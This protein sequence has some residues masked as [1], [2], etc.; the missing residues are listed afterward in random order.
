MKMDFEKSVVFQQNN[1]IIIE[2]QSSIPPTSHYMFLVNITLIWALFANNG[3]EVLCCYLLIEI[4]ASCGTCDV[5]SF[6]F[7]SHNIQ[8]KQITC[9]GHRKND[10]ENAFTNKNQANKLICDTDRLIYTY[11]ETTIS[12]SHCKLV[13]KLIKNSFAFLM[14]IINKATAS[15]ASLLHY[16]HHAFCGCQVEGSSHCMLTPLDT[17]VPKSIK[18]HTTASD[19][20]SNAMINEL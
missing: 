15:F 4:K 2:C 18:R 19:V 16:T 9:A 5:K 8:V 12:Q 1:A 20:T 6:V 3:K 14:T 17:E 13:F 10:Q 7:Q 11:K